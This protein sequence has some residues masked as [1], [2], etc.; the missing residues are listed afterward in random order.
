MTI[1]KIK[2]EPT[3]SLQGLRGSSGHWSQG[4]RGATPGQDVGGGNRKYS[5]NAGG[6][7]GETAGGETAGRSCAGTMEGARRVLCTH[8]PISSA[9][10]LSSIES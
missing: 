8:L 7:G 1:R 6:Q 4:R 2:R 10:S 3:W 5:N 9:A